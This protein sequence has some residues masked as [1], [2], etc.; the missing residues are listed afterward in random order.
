MKKAGEQMQQGQQEDKEKA[1]EE[2][3]KGAQD[4]KG[5]HR[6]MRRQKARQEAER[7]MSKL[8]ESLRKGQKG[9]QRQQRAQA[10][11]RSFRRRSAGPG[12]KSGK[13]KKSQAGLRKPGGRKKAEL[14]RKGKKS[15]DRGVGNQPGSDK[16]GRAER[17]KSKRTDHHVKGKERGG[18][19]DQE[20]ILAAA[21]KG[22]AKTGYRD[23]FTKYRDVAEEELATDRVPAGYRRYVYR[24][25][26]LIRP[27]QG[28]G[29]TATNKGG[30]R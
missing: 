30:Q 11:R 10:Q 5:M 7:R 9:G 16:L 29:G 14:E 19:M 21:K 24:Y 8:K 26:D 22:F 15:G 4:I 2:M 3:M 12:A 23:V 28:V 18:P 27:A 20:V 13:P 1:S 6:A 17:L 25:F